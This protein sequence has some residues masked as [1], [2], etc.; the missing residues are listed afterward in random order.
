MKRTLEKYVEVFNISIFLI[1][2]P[3][4]FI[5]NTPTW[6]VLQSKL[7][8]RGFVNAQ[9]RVQSMNTSVIRRHLRKADRCSAARVSSV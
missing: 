4:L 2:P 1:Y 6:S 9:A 5:E 8:I 7:F 3:Y